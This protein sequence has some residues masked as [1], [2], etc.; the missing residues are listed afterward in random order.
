MLSKAFVHCVI[1]HQLWFKVSRCHM[2][3]SI[4]TYKNLEYQ[5]LPFLIIWTISNYPYHCT[6]WQNLF[7]QNKELF[8]FTNKILV[9]LW[10]IFWKIDWTPYHC[11][12]WDFEPLLYV[13]FHEQQKCVYDFHSLSLADVSKLATS[14]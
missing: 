11:N 6:M 5:K 3:A 13:S 9:D 8:F 2:L 14:A 1:S 10:S 4:G 7:L 12:I